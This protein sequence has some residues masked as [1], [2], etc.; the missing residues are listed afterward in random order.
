MHPKEKTSILKVQGNRAICPV[1]R[2][3]TRTVILPTTTVSNFPLYCHRCRQ[4][5]I[6][7]Y[8][9]LSDNA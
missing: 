3:V 9:R 2:A 1:C 6:V 4:T 5:T 7:N 8:I